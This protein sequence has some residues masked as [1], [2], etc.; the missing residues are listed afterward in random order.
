MAFFNASSLFLHDAMYRTAICVKRWSG[1][2]QHKGNP[3]KLK[4]ENGGISHIG[5]TKPPTEAPFFLF[6]GLIQPILYKERAPVSP[7]QAKPGDLVFFVG[8][9][10]TAGM[11]HVGLY[12][13]NSVMLHCGDPIS[14][15]NLNSSYWQQHFYCYGR[16][17]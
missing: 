17:P 4:T 2:D 15:T 16:L 10:D 8:T 14:Y 1:L 13:G 11:S 3:S 9:Y 5:M 6:G 12:V 7:E